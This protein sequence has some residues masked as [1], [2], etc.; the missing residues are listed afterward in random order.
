MERIRASM[1]STAKSGQQVGLWAAIYRDVYSVSRFFSK[2]VDVDDTDAH[3]NSRGTAL[4]WAAR[5]GSVDMVE[6]LISRNA[7]LFSRDPDGRTAE[8][9]AL[10]HGHIQMA[11]ILREAMVD[12]SRLCETMKN[13]EPAQRHSQRMLFAHQNGN[14]ID[15]YHTNFFTRI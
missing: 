15:N 10:Y 7:D 9:L 13:P 2:G 5:N 11:A 14:N 4:H 3:T 1:M 8:D 6:V 12:K